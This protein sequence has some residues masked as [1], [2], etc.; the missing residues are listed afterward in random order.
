MTSVTVEDRVVDLD[1]ARTRYLMA[2]DGPPLLCLHGMG[3]GNSANSFDPI[4]PRLAEHHQVYA[5]DMLGFGL[6][7]RDVLEGPTFSLLVDH[8]REFMD[9]LGLAS[10]HLLGHSAG[11]WIGG[12][13]A[14]ESPQR[15]DR[16]I[17]LC[18]AGLNT[19][20]AA[21]IRR[22]QIPT[23]AQIEDH[24]NQMLL[25]SNKVSEKQVTA[26]VAAQQAALSRPGALHSLD[27][28]LHQMETPALRE[29]Y[30][31]QRRLDRISVPTLVAWGE[32]D[33]MAPYPT[34]T[35]EYEALGGDM[36]RSSQP[37][38]IPGARYVLMPTG[39]H[40]MVEA[41]GATAALILEFLTE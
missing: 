24:L 35:Q 21:G 27:T 29:R 37:W 25:D 13:L 19:A 10:T 15:I 9:H 41:P 4:F 6:G 18:G 12:L 23:A 39:H 32:G 34:W 22:E 40:P 26:F 3:I 36:S 2:G 16:L 30:M 28:L 33:L 1:L 38:V 7:E 14:Y 17:M 20:P 11:G 8:V 5:L 31:L